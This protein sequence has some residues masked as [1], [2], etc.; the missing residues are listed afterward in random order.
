VHRR[1][2]RRLLDCVEASRSAISAPEEANARHVRQGRAA[3]DAG[4]GLAALGFLALNGVDARG[5]EATCAHQCRGAPTQVFFRA[6]GSDQIEGA[7]ASNGQRYSA[8]PL[9]FRYRSTVDNTCTCGATSARESSAALFHDLTLRK[10][11]FVMTAT[12]VRVFRGGRR[13]PYDAND[14]TDLAPSSLPRDTRDSLVAMDR[15]NARSQGTS[16]SEAAPDSR[17]FQDAGIRP[18]GSVAAS[19][20]AAN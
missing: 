5:S 11:D 17:S 20:S 6:A 3:L 4:A 14:F 16:A 8:L 1:A 15:A 10:G 18:L 7:I 13:P 9:A 12:G 2:A 19:S